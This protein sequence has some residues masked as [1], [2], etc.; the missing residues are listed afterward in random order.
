MAIIVTEAL[1]HSASKRHVAKHQGDGAWRVSWLPDRT[2]TRNESLTAMR[3]AEAIDSGLERG[4]QLWPHI[5]DWR[6]SSECPVP[7][8]L[9][10]SAR[11]IP[12][13]HR[14]DHDQPD[15]LA[16]RGDLEGT[17]TRSPVFG[18]AGG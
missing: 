15:L 17:R 16:E 6:R 14:A 11:R 1:M 5:Q 13:E 4:N 12:A 9:S 2:L 18:K 10:E 8:P 7:P 3:L